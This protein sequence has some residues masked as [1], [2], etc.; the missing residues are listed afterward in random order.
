M[1]I[2]GKTH[3]EEWLTLFQHVSEE[4][5][6]VLRTEFKRGRPF[7]EAE[8]DDEGK[9][10]VVKTHEIGI[11]T[12][13]RGHRRMRPVGMPAE[14]TIPAPAREPGTG[15]VPPAPFEHPIP[16]VGASGTRRDARH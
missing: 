10:A 15:G 13:A 3:R 12:V 1:E 16:A 5:F 6:R 14:H 11:R 4:Y 7:S 9:V 8:I 2:A